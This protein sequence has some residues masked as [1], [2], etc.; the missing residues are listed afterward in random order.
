MIKKLFKNKKGIGEDIIIDIYVFL[1]IIA[2]LIFAFF[3]FDITAG[4]FVFDYTGDEANVEASLYLQNYLRSNINVDGEN[5]TISTLINKAVDDNI[6][7]ELLE[8]HTE[9]LFESF[10][11]GTS[12]W[13]LT[14]TYMPDDNKLLSV[15]TYKVNAIMDD[16]ST[17]DLAS[18]AETFVPL[19]T[20][21][22]Y[23]I[24]TLYLFRDNINDDLIMISEESISQEEDQSPS[25]EIVTNESIGQAIADTAIQEYEWWDGR[26]ECDSDETEAK[27]NEYFSV[28]SFSEVEC[29][30][31]L[32]E[33]SAQWSGTFISWILK[34]NN[35]DF[36]YS[37]SH[38]SY[39]SYVRNHPGKYS[40]K[41]YPMSDIDEL[42]LGDILCYCEGDTCIEDGYDSDVPFV[43]YQDKKYSMLSHCDFVVNINSETNVEIIGGNLGDTS[44]RYTVNINADKY[45]GFISCN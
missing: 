22:N 24:A 32:S 45:I 34:Q 11:E 26:N 18:A 20:P 19:S 25:E 37:Y 6:Y 31:Y 14:L 39:F 3:I 36:P 44:M 12:G 42:K 41:T 16:I 33:S 4:K 35:I 23:V 1:V 30:S 2:L 7:L 27:L 21:E 17:P 43:Y 10:S 28:V 13:H 29:A 40:C 15:N 38:S 8:D 9:E 5:M